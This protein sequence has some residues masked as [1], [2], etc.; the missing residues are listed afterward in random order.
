MNPLTRAIVRGFG[1]FRCSIYYVTNYSID[2]KA[3]NVIL[4]LMDCFTRW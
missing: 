4:Q 3:L 1:V 2:D